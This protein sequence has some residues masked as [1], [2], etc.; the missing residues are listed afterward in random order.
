MWGYSYAQ[1][2]NLVNLE[3]VFQIPH[4]ILMNFIFWYVISHH[5]SHTCIQ[6]GESITVHHW[7]FD[8]Y[9]ETSCLHSTLHND[10]PAPS[11]EVKQDS[12]IIAFHCIFLSAYFQ[13]LIPRG[14]ST[15]PFLAK[16]QS[17]ANLNTAISTRGN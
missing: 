6:L 17:T 15:W 1:L 9:F 4:K 8:Q 10:T 13:V 14:I 11:L 5:K 16:K 12:N 3:L 7:T 2:S